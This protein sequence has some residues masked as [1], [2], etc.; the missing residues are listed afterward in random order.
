MCGDAVVAVA[1]NV[2]AVTSVSDGGVDDR[3][4]V[5]SGVVDGVVDVDVG[6]NV[7]AVVVIVV[8]MPVAVGCAAIAPVAIHV[9]VIAGVV[10]SVKDGELLWW[11]VVVCRSRFVCFDVSIESVH[12][13]V[14]SCYGRE[15]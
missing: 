2:A 1:V 11:G 6:V 14:H 10:V 5:P 12:R 9:G 7:I 15:P 8:V 4:V 13:S 3:A